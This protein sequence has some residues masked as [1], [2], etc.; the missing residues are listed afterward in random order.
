V[1]APK[2][3]SRPA[4]I[5]FSHVIQ[6]SQNPIQL[7]EAQSNAV[8]ARMEL[9]LRLGAAFTRMQTLNLQGM[10]PVRGDERGKLISYGSCQFPTLGFVVDRYLRVRNFVP[11]PFW[12]I[13]VHHTKDDVEVKFNWRRGHQEVETTSSHHCRAAKDGK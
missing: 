2:L 7:D 11:E 3:P 13:K 1:S 10:I 5:C 6:A 8:A 12:Y 4:L 9:D